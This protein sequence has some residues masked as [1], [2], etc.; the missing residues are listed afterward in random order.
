MEFNR[1]RLS[2]DWGECA[3]K[4]SVTPYRECE[5]ISIIYNI[6]NT[7][8]SP[9]IYIIYIYQPFNYRWIRFALAIDCLFH[10]VFWLNCLSIWKCFSFR[11]SR[12]NQTKIKLI[13]FSRYYLQKTH[14]EVLHST[15]CG[16]VRS[17]DDVRLKFTF[18]YYIPEYMMNAK[19]KQQQWITHIQ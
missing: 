17:G 13:F 10:S 3:W 2:F 16:L 12:K 8:E 5:I 9:W 7:L 4:A 11:R 14:S 6:N 19:I 18:I 15:S 1:K